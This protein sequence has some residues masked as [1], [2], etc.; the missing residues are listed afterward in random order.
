[1]CL[2][3]FCRKSFGRECGQSPAQQP[4]GQ[5]ARLVAQ[6]GQPQT[7]AA[8]G[9]GGAV[10]TVDCRR[11]HAGHARPPPRRGEGGGGQ[12]GQCLLLGASESLLVL[13]V[14]PLHGSP[15]NGDHTLVREWGNGDSS[16]SDSD[17]LIKDVLT[18]MSCDFLKINLGLIA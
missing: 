18:P 17:V 16:D 11:P 7:A 10:F 6:V 14:L 15:A 3:G 2:C 12:G 9:R 1:M 4:G 13:V 5:G 8:G